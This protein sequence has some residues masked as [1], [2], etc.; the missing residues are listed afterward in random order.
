M[1]QYRKMLGMACAVLVPFAILAGVAMY[2]MDR[3]TRQDI[4]RTTGGKVDAC[5][6]AVDREIGRHVAVLQTLGTAMDGDMRHLRGH[7]EGVFSQMQPDWLTVVLAE[8]GRQLFN[9]RLQ[10]HEPL[11]PSRDPAANART[12]AAQTVTVDGVAID[13]ARLA[14]PFIS[15]RAPV[16]RLNG[17]ASPYVL[18]AAVRAWTFTLTLKACG[19]PDPEWRIGVVD[20]EGRIVGRSPSVDPNDPLIGRMSTPSYREGL[21]SGQRFFF[22]QT[23]DDRPI[24][25]GVAVSA[26]YGWALSLTIPAQDVQGAI[27]RVWILTGATAGGGLF[28]AGLAC[29]MSLRAYG[30]AATTNR[31]EASLREKDIL[32]REIHHR[33]KNNLQA[34]WGM[35]QFERSRIK[36]PFAKARIEVIMGRV[37]VLGSIHQQLYES[38]SLNRINFGAHLT[39]LV[40]RVRESLDPDRI[41]LTLNAEP[42]YCDLE[43]ALPCG[44]IISELISNAQRHAFPHDRTG[45]VTV[46]LKRHEDGDVRLGVFDNGAGLNG[47]KPGI[48][49]VLVGLLAGQCEAVVDVT[50]PGGCH[51]CVTVPGRLFFAQGDT[52]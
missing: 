27:R 11:P 48:G 47:S 36:D 16:R 37:L 40:D 3:N 19:V 46:M 29:V 9:L 30:R 33:V 25:A 14:E 32:L 4:E 23:I 41:T 51:A 35:M 5:L 12:V 10:P 18:I 7:A 1:Q 15:I 45:T 43:T 17:S 22:A 50:Y 13:R 26:R 39:E 28:V 38:E 52:A 8:G 20:A 34:M 2:E 6:A 24:F 42:L 31:L 49:M 44:L 21:Y